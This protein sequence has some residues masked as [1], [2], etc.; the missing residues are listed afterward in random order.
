MRY[1]ED[2]NAGD[3]RELGSVTISESEIVEFASRFDP[4]T[5]HVDPEAA[6]EGPFGGLIASGWHTTAVFM[7]MFFRAVLL[8]SASLGSPGVEEIRWLAPVRPG[9]EL[10]GRS[11]ILETRAS[12]T[13]AGR[14]TVITRNEVLNQDDVVVM[15]MKARG[16]FA[17]RAT[18]T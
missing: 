15:T 2:F 11:T 14:G 17:R 4:Q 6:K 7:G 12:E 9:D 1:F 8:D 5:F 18:S 10:R 16:F 13:N 3:V